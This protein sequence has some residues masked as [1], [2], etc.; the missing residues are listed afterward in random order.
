MMLDDAGSRIFRVMMSVVSCWNVEFIGVLRFAM[1]VRA[2]PVGKRELINVNVEKWRCRGNAVIEISGVITLAIRS[3]V[4]GGMFVRGGV[5]R[6]NVG[7]AR[8]KGRGRV[9]VESEHTK[10]WPV[11]LLCHYVGPLVISC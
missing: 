1:M 2:S 10:G 8:V 3:W 7:I 5:M 11:M 6:V 4:A 9:L